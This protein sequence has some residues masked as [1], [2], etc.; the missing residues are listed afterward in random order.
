MTPPFRQWPEG[1][2]PGILEPYLW[3]TV[4]DNDMVLDLRTG[5]T[6]HTVRVQGI[7]RGPET[8]GDS[9]A[10]VEALIGN[11]QQVFLNGVARAVRE[12]MYRQAEDAIAAAEAAGWALAD[13]PRIEMTGTLRHD[14]DAGVD[15]PCAECRV[16]L[17]FHV[18]DASGATL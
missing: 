11:G 10:D 5:I 12:S 8:V 1:S 13:H 9:G 7:V 4:A 15:V 3:V 6:L 14:K 17:R 18:P 16:D 2:L